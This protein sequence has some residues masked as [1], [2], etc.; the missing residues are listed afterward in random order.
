MSN[1]NPHGLEEFI[2]RRKFWNESQRIRRYA[3]H[4][5]RTGRTSD[6][7]Q[8]YSIAAKWSHLVNIGKLTT[9][10]WNPRNP[11]SMSRRRRLSGK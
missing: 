8:S 6:L 7:C 10:I 5:R 11:K 9:K 3:K 4:I 2:K 1:S